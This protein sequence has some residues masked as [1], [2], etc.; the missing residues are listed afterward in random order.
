MEG[1]WFEERVLREKTG[2]GRSAT[3]EHVPK[4]DG[5][6][7]RLR[8]NDQ[9]TTRLCGDLWE[10]PLAATNHSYGAATNAADSLRKV[11]RREELL[12][13]Q[14]WNEVI[15][16]QQEI[17]AAE[18]ARRNIRYLETTTRTTYT[19]PQPTQPVG[20]RVM[21]T[22]DGKET[23]AN[24]EAFLVEHGLRETKPRRPLE[25]LDAEVRAAKLPITLYSE[26]L[27][28]GHFPISVAK[29]PSPFARTAGFTQPLGATRAAAHFP[30]N[31]TG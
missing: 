18:E 14:L 9:T 17:K 6:P 1:N 7:L 24:D 23:E 30:G 22:Q 10:E 13:Q 27:G 16:N 11:G 8:P 2:F 31:I 26:T 12:T 19:G 25:Q 4:K 5:E 20:K 15:Q 29:G 3:A 28:T 21:K